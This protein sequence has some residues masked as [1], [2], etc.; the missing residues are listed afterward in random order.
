M[1]YTEHRT[2]TGETIKGARVIEAMKA[3]CNEWRELAQE[4]RVEDSYAKH[5]TEAQKDEFLAQSIILADDLESGRIN[6]T[7]TD[8]QRVNIHL[9]GDCVALLA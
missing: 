8:W 3:V 4:I 9:T 1:K 2:H 7:L 6:P 5:I